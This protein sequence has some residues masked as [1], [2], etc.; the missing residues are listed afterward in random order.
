MISKLHC[1][2]P[3][4]FAIPLIMLLWL[5]G[6][7]GFAGQGCCS[8]HGGVAGCAGAKLQCIDGTVSPTCSCQ[9]GAASPVSHGHDGLAF[10]GATPPEG[11]RQSQ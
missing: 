8:A 11:K 6:N 3:K 2:W 9:D 1:M 4:R 5:Q 7:L 10:L